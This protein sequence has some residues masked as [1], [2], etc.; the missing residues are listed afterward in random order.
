M[1][2]QHS[3]REKIALMQESESRMKMEF[4]NLSNRIFEDR[5]RDLGLENRKR[6]DGILQ[7]LRKQLDSFRKRV[8]EVHHSDTEQS[9]RLV[10]Q[11]RQLQVLS[12]RVSEE[13]NMRARAIKGDSKK[14]GDWG[15]MIIEKIF[16]ASGL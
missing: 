12:G 4:E 8:D 9:A 2:E 10:E 6:M 14:Q 3:A 16:E 1:N 11:V 7:P 5:G 13:A 15:G